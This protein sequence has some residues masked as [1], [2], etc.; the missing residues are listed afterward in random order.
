MVNLRRPN[1]PA[2]TRR[3]KTPEKF[4][5]AKSMFIIATHRVTRIT[6]NQVRPIPS[7]TSPC[8]T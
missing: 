3:I 7:G 6:C 1:V 2:R 4:S 8:V 5:D